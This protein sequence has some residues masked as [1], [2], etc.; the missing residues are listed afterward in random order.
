MR[1]QLGSPR[2]RVPPLLKRPSH[3]VRG[4][5]VQRHHLTPRHDR[6]QEI[7]GVVGEQH[8]ETLEPAES[9]VRHST[10]D[11]TDVDVWELI[12]D[13][14]MYAARGWINA[15]YPEGIFWYVDVPFLVTEPAAG[16]HEEPVTWTRVK[17]LYR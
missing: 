11:M 12:D 8:Y 10:W 4:Q 2:V 1:Q 3:L 6:G 17:A 5:R 14:G 15:F 9:Y 13:P 7:L 16:L